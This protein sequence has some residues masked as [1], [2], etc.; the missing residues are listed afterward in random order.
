M[1]INSILKILS[2]ENRL[3][4]FNIIKEDALCVGEIQTILNLTQSN[5]SR[6]LDRMKSTGMITYYKKAQ[7]VI[8]KLSEETVK[9]YPFIKQLLFEN[10]KDIDVYKKDIA[11]LTKYKKSNLT[12]RDLKEVSFDYSKIKF[13]D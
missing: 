8:Y 5:V 7:W 1:E 2:D 13:K 9:N 4:M 6:H 11:R 10:I 12:C 3:R